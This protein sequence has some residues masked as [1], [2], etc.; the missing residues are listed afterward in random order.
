MSEVREI[1]LCDCREHG[2]VI[3]DIKE[4]DCHEIY[5]ALF[6]YKN[7]CSPQGFWERI[8]W[9]LQVL[10]TGQ[11]WTDEICLEVKDAKKLGERLLELTKDDK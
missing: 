9:C 8:R 3:T 1:F 6:Q 2:L 5:L 11:P 7:L 10:K 4:I